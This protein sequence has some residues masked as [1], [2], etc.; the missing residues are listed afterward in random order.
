MENKIIIRSKIKDLRKNMDIPKISSQIID[1]ILNL[2]VYKNAK[3]IMLFYPLQYEINLLRLM[4]LSQDKNFYLPRMNGK[5]LECC[6]YNLS[7]KLICSRYQIF[8]PQT[9]AVDKNCIDI[10]FVPAL[11]T[12]KNFNRLGYGGGY[13]DR[14]LDG[15]EKTKICPCAETFLYENIPSEVYDIK[16]DFIVTEKGIL[17]K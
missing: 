8:E 1:N 7:D 11:C 6:S 3:N 17:K 13:Y 14:F 10:V 15:Y 9:E 2:E 4:E 16:M 12:D 5:D